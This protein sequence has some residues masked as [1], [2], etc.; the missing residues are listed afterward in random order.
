[1]KRITAKRLIK[2][3]SMCPEYEPAPEISSAADY[4]LIETAYQMGGVSF[5]YDAETIT[6]TIH[7]FVRFVRKVK[8]QFEEKPAAAGKE[9]PF[10][11][12]RPYDWEPVSA[13]R[14]PLDCWIKLRYSNL[15]KFVIVRRRLD[16][17]AMR[18]AWYDS[19]LISLGCY[20][21]GLEPVTWAWRLP[22]MNELASLPDAVAFI[23]E[24]AV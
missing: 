16:G 13:G 1:M 23:K 20:H 12:T 19:R 21:A 6:M 7:D 17:A 15:E 18:N 22:T 10:T 24:A 3:A 5:D 8:S 9:T 2:R 11:T 4:F 14:F